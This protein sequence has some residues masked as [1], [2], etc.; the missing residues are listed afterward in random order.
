MPVMQPSG[1]A[2]LPIVVARALSESGNHLVATLLTPVTIYGA[3]KA[4]MT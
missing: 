2:R 3:G 1:V 4:H